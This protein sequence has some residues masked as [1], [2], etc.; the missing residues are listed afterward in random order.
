M[1]M[2]WTLAEY[3]TGKTHRIRSERNESPI[4][5][6]SIRLIRIKSHLNIPQSNCMSSAWW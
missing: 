1:W 5:P 3:T 4:T 2:N 6:E